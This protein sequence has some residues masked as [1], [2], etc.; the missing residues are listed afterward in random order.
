MYCLLSNVILVHDIYPCK[1]IITEIYSV[2][3]FPLREQCLT[4]VQ[5]FLWVH[6][7]DPIDISKHNEM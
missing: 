7:K 5:L 6:L 2:E 1:R 3:I 4:N